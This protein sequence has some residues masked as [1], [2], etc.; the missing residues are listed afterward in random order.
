M[1]TILKFFFYSIALVILVWI[2]ETPAE[3]VTIIE[4]V[5]FVQSPNW[6]FNVLFVEVLLFVLNLT[7]TGSLIGCASKG[8]NTRC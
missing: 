1:N 5:R 7:L 2:H 8:N 3:S 4:W 6:L